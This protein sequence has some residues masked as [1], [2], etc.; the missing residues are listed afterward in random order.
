MS[1][2]IRRR[3]D[4]DHVRL[5][6]PSAALISFVPLDDKRIVAARAHESQTRY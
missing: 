1:L 6:W 5:T 3:S 4:V 2:I